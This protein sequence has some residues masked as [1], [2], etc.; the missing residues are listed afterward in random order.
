LVVDDELISSR[1][2]DVELK[3]VS[4]RKSG[5]DGP[6]SDC[7][8]NSLSNVM[9]DMCLRTKGISQEEN[10]DRL[11][12]TIGASSS[13]TNNLTV[14]FDRG[15]GKFSRVESVAKRNLN[16]LTIANVFGARHPFISSEQ[17][18]PVSKRWAAKGV[19]A[20]EINQR[21]D[22]CKAFMLDEN[23]MLGA[24]VRIAKRS[25][26]GK[27]V[28]AVAVRDIFDRNAACKDIKFFV[29]TITKPRVTAPYTFVA[30]PKTGRL[31]PNILFSDTRDVSD[32]RKMVE[33]LLLTNCVPLTIGQRC[34]DWFLLRGQLLS[35]TIAGKL[36]KNV[37]PDGPPPSEELLSRAMDD[38]LD[39][40]YKRHR[41]TDAMVAAG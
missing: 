8:S 31:C 24:E 6:V 20:S 34:A 15:Y 22:L 28:F 41:S 27:E 11:L 35:G 21:K 14:A 19:P 32:K 37:D 17:W 25:V 26:R 23:S 12:D 38:C 10:V 36:T 3:T 16:I 33:Q 9:F 7:L 4:S 18:E 13:V 1:A 30:V 29:T 40:W 39:S 2:N 5:K